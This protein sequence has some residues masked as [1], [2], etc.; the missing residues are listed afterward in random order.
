MEDILTFNT[1][2]QLLLIATAILLIIQT[3]YYLGIYN[4]IHVRSRAVEHEN[5]N[6]S[7]ELPPITVIICAREEVENLRHNLVSVLEQDYPEF[8]VIVIN[9][10]NTDE[11]EDYL[12]L[13]NEKYPNLYHSFVPDSSRYISRK[14]LAITLGVKASKYD[15]LVFTEAN[16]KPD[17]D[18][19]LR[20]IARN[21]TPSTQIVLG[22]S[23][24]ERGNKMLHK[25]V[26]FDNL[27]HSMRYLGYALA[28]QPYI[29]IGRNMA[30][31]KELFY[32]QKGFSAYLNLQRGD[33]DLFIN[34]VTTREN[35]R[36]ETDSNSIVRMEPIS[37]FSDW[38]EEKIGYVSTS[39]YY[40]G[41]QKYLSGME[42]T[43]R[44]L[45]HV[46]WITTL[47]I[48]I[49]N[50]HWVVSGVAF[51]AFGIRYTIQAI[52][53]NRTA[54]DLSEQRRYYITLPIYDFMQP[55]QSLRWKLFYLFRKKRN[56]M[57][58]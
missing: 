54:R 47:T 9:D 28:G 30:Y 15:W 4:R 12:V 51:V 52:I 44:L 53:I 35:T 43:T 7:E 29:G 22:Y 23:G 39:R 27:F 13:L 45:F 6:F 42:T 16:C 14:K 37:R 21:F 1:I 18:Q 24:Y 57:R 55:L 25:R 2:E 56:F 48:G 17:S 31:R 40:K 36:V 41:I 33:D 20:T 58:K 3:I 8:E 46:A 34:K 38:Q 10:G 49:V 19:W 5:I 32:E 50:Q 26:A 11:S